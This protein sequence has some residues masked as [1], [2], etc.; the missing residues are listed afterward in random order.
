MSN[1][2]TTIKSASSDFAAEIEEQKQSELSK[3]ML[4]EDI[5]TSA[6]LILEQFADGFMSEQPKIDVVIKNF[7]AYFTGLQGA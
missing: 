1:F 7:I 2:N 4:N 3:Q 5:D 6:E